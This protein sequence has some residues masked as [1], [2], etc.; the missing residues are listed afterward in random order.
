MTEDPKPQNEQNKMTL[1]ESCAGIQRNWRRAPGHAELLQGGN[2]HET[3]R[4]GLI[5]IRQVQQGH[6]Q[7]QAAHSQGGPYLPPHALEQDGGPGG[8]AK[9]MQAPNGAWN[10]RGPLYFSHDGTISFRQSAA[11][12]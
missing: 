9:T 5:T 6:A 4:H 10:L 3:R 1:C 12:G 7:E 11:T 2:R 8:E